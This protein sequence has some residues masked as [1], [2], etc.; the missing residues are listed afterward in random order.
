MLLTVL[1]FGCGQSDPPTRPVGPIPP[2]AAF[3][4]SPVSGKPETHF[5]VDASEAFSRFGT[6]VLRWDWEG[7]GVWDTDFSTEKVATHAYT[8][9]G[10]QKIRLE[11]K[12]G[13]EVS[14]TAIR[15]VF[16][17]YASKE[18]I[19]IP[20][21]EFVMGSQ[22][23]VGNDDEHPP[24]KVYLDA[25]LIAKYEVTNQQYT[26][27]LNAWGKNDDGA[28]H[29]LVDLNVSL[30]KYK[31]PTYSVAKKWTD[32]PVVGVNW[33]G[34]NAYAQWEGDRLPTEAEWEKAA[35]GTDEREW[36]W[37][38]LWEVGNANS[39]E[40]GRERPA[41]VGSHQSGASPYGVHDL[42]GNVYEW[43]SDW[44]QKDYYQISPPTKP[45]RARCRYRS[46]L[47]RWLLVRTGREM[48]CRC[49]VRQRPRGGR[50]RFWLS[51]CQRCWELAGFL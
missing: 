9:L 41:P 40:S 3:A 8:S 49:P 27:F 12:D 37:G 30:I 25:F 23:G 13:R 11:V 45:E 33:Y 26:E 4:I 20:A 34:A 10:H 18:M 22:K 24:H 15:E 36:P 39:W 7:D 5:R 48:S 19:P 14:A 1:S 46:R 42:A 38:D 21:G 44:Y 43:V 31:D 51:H 28:G 6:I 35:R 16:V 29:A 50:R 32:H 47:A 17:T 2:R